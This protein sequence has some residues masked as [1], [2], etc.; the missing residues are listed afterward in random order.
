M[1][2]TGECSYSFISGATG[3]LGRAF[4]FA[5]APDGALF[6]TGRNWERLDKLRQEVL[7]KYPSCRIDC[8]ACDLTDAGARTRLFN[9][10]DQ[11]G[12][13]FHRLCNVAGVDIQKAFERYTQE[14][15][16]LQCR[17]NFEATLSLTRFILERRAQRMEIITIGSIS[18]VYPMPFFALY[19]ASKAA[20]ES[21]FSSLRVELKD[22]GVHGTVVEPGGIYTR[23]DICKDIAG[24]GLWGKLSAKTPEYVAQK[25]LHAVRRNR[26]V[27]R[28][29]FWNQWIAVVPR[30][31]PLG[32]RMR[33][34]AWRWRKLE[35]DA[36]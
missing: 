18:G 9:Y 33:F 32:V 12:Y 20:L 27:V 8:F 16:V 30:L 10:L 15:I 34:I 23:P 13:R 14:K 3:G 19:S 29:G 28:P 21:F 24:Q 11:K 4:T 2:T 7:Q 36:F 6:L 25:S 31:L 17:V 5:C 35:K 26:R 22:S 1:K